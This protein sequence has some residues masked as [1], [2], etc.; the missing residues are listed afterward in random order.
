MG[1]SSYQLSNERYPRTIVRLRCK[2]QLLRDQMEPKFGEIGIVRKLYV[3]GV[4]KGHI[5]KGVI[6]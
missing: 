5:M 1:I 6:L 3:H 2:T 4:E